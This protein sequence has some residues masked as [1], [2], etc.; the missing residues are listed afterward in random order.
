MLLM[1]VINAYIIYYKKQDNSVIIV[2]SILIFEVLEKCI[3]VAHWCLSSIVLTMNCI[4]NNIS[5][6]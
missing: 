4:D 2:T 6:Y 5:V 3:S 1:R